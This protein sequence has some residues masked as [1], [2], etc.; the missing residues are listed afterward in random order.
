MKNDKRYKLKTAPD[1]EAVPFTE[2]KA[3]L[4]ILHSEKDSEIQSITKAVIKEVQNRIGRQLALAHWYMYLDGFPIGD[5]IEI[6][7]GP[8][9]G[10]TAVRYW[11]PGASSYTE[12]SSDSYQLDNTE[13]SARLRFFDTLNTDQNRMNTVEIEFTTGWGASGAIPEDLHDA[14][15]LIA[16]ERFLNPENPQR[17][18]VTRA[19]ALLRNYTVHRW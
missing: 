12:L 7:K 15:V 3:N 14:V 2:V 6:E 18:K 1:F 16:S 13:L 8:V 5:E 17:T 19:D 4:N 9:S 10:I 11:A